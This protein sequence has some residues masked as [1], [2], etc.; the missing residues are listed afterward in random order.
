MNQTLKRIDIWKSELGVE[1]PFR[2]INQLDSRAR[3]ILLLRAGGVTLKEVGERI[4]KSVER[5][6]QLESRAWRALCGIRA[7]E[8]YDVQLR[9]DV[10]QSEL[11]YLKALKKD[12]KISG[13][14][15]GENN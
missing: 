2:D 1:N 4:G 8:T 6:R 11:L 9:K 14:D 10:E 7:Q 13:L 12:I 3:L 5:T 15:E